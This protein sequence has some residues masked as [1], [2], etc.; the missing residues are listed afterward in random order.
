[1]DEISFRRVRV[2]TE[3]GRGTREVL[4]SP[5]HFSS[6]DRFIEIDSSDK[7][8]RLSEERMSC[9]DI[10]RREKNKVSIFFHACV[11]SSLQRLLLLLFFFFSFK[12]VTL[13][14]KNLTFP[15]HPRHTSIQIN[16]E[17]ELKIWKRQFLPGV[18]FEPTL[19]IGNQNLSLAP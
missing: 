17:R 12:H 14:R 3:G 16:T 9:R 18:G 19:P 13:S 10:R 6:I 1:M 7:L 15:R 2:T 5:R 4:P 8:K 11:V